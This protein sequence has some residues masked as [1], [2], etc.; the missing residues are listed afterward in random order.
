MILVDPDHWLLARFD[1]TLPLACW[2][3]QLGRDPHPVGR[4]AAAQALGRHAS[5]E[6]VAWLAA[7]LRRERVWFVQAEIAAALGQARSPA[8]LAALVRAVRIADPR[9]R[10][11]AVRALG[12]FRSAQVGPLLG[13]LAAGDPSYFVAAEALRGLGRLRDPAVLPVLRRALRE[14]DSWNDTVRVAAVEGL[15][16]LGADGTLATLR[17]RT[18]YG[19]PHPSRMAAARSLGRVGR[20]DPGA[21][22][23]LL[24]LTRDPFL[25]VQLAAISALGHLGDDRAVPR[26]E[27]LVQAVDVDG[28]VRRTAAEA[29]R[30]IR[31]DSDKR[32]RPREPARVPAPR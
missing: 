17:A 3:A 11:A 28:R 10:R 20:G 25:R 31:G 29:L 24:A 19:L 2:R 23:T 14:A 30:A 8:A 27:R 6:A 5:A 16:E 22:R 15:A 7:A 12:E 21:L 32:L 13:R 1:L 18:R 4:I 9:V 26:L